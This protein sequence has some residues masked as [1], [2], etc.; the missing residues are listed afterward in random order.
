[1]CEAVNFN[2]PGQLVIAG[3]RGAVE[4]AMTTVK[5]HGAK[6][7]ILLPV[8]AP[9]HSSLLKPAAE[10]LAARLAGVAFTAPAIPV[11]HN[12]DVAEHG[13]AGAIR[14]ALAAQAASPVRWADTIRTIR[15]R[16]ITTLIECGPGKVLTNLMRRIDETM[17]AL[18]TSDDIDIDAALA[19]V[20]V[21]R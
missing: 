13:S 1:V 21:A 8:S 18:A 15:G 9:F 12:V 14:G 17:T 19:A 11:L 3:H 7:A 20:K 6:R 2:A 4:R 5:A 10:H 16:G